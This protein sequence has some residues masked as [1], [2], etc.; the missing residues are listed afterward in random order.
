MLRQG[1][2]LSL[3]AADSMKLT[4]GQLS[5]RIPHLCLLKAEITGRPP[6]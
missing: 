4:V 6:N 1:F 5:P 2:S 3:K